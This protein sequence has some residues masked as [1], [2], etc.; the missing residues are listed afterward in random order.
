MKH[1]FLVVCTAMALAIGVARCGGGNMANVRDRAQGSACETSCQEGRDK[2]S[3]ECAEAVSSGKSTN[4]EP[5]NIACDEAR[6][7]CNTDCKN[8]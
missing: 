7:K 3:T 5:C 8:R 2:C 6:N 1:V 4:S